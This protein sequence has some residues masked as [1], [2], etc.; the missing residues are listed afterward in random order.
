MSSHV[1]SLQVV[2]SFLATLTQGSSQDGRIVLETGLGPQKG[3]RRPAAGL[4]YVVLNAAV[5]FKEVVEEARAVVLIGGTLQPVAP[6]VSQLF[7]DLPPA[8][9]DVFA[10]GHVIPP[11]NLTALC[12]SKGPTG[13]AF[14]FTHKSRGSPQQM[15][16]LGRALLNVC[17]VTPGGVVVFLPSY[18]YEDVGAGVNLPSRPPLCLSVC[19]LTVPVFPHPQNTVLRRWREANLLAKLQAKKPIFN[20][21]KRAKDVDSVLAAYAAAIER[22][23][24]AL[25]FCV[26]GAKMSEGINFANEMARCV[27]MVGLP[28]PDSRDPELQQ[29][30]QYLDGLKTRAGAVFG[31]S[32][33][34]CVFVR[35]LLHGSHL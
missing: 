19:A 33:W 2:Q 9:I 15:D 16:E 11:E 12:L 17:T 34:R 10:C 6:L 14:D 7:P 18:Q 29:K 24:G 1:S 21:P 5:H 25:L 4:K 3:R 35:V 22:T 8:R 27:V 13:V 31:A 28:Y 30:L 26:V 23:G 32:S 20:E